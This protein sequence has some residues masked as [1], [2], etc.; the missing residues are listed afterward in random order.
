M[1]AALDHLRSRGLIAVENATW[2]L[3]VPIESIYLEAPESLRQMIELQIE[4]LSK[5]EQ[6]VLEIASVAGFS[7]TANVNALGTTIDRETFDSVCDDLSRRPLMVRRTVSNQFS[8]GIMSECYEFAHPLY[9][10]VFYRRQTPARRAKL[11]LC[12][13]GRATEAPP[14]S[15]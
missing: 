7:L 15:A 10:E 13:G 3:K 8:G 2:Q 4:R 11:P 14:L 12:I 6:R 9:R 1:V 5:E